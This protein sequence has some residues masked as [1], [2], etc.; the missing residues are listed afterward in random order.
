MKFRRALGREAS[1]DGWVER[2]SQ[3]T[4]IFLCTKRWAPIDL[5]EPVSEAD[6]CSMGELR[7]AVRASASFDVLPVSR[8][9]D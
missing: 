2:E 8:L 7:F 5:N 6:Y 1:A 4:Q 3:Q 9:I